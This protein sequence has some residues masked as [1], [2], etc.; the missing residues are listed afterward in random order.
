M[1]N[2]GDGSLFAIAEEGVDLDWI[3][4]PSHMRLSRKDYSLRGLIQT[5]YPD[6]QCHYGDAMYFMQCSILAPKNI[7][8]DEVNNAILESLSGKLH[9]YLSAN[10]LIPTE[11]KCKCYCRSFNGFIVS[12]GISEHFVIQRYR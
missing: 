3:K 7:N 8:I 12:G 11:R 9:M 10:S 5:I 4:I 6:H 2:V 1:L